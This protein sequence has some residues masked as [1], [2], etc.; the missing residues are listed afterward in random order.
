MEELEALHFAAET[1]PHS[2]TRMSSSPYIV[3]LEAALLAHVV[4][5]DTDIAIR[6]SGKRGAKLKTDDRLLNRY[7]KA[8]IKRER[9]RLEKDEELKRRYLARMTDSHGASKPTTE[10]TD[11]SQKEA[12]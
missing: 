8:A 2:V 12:P 11:G 6:Q 7:D 1:D 4:D 5:T 10:A 3:S 9:K